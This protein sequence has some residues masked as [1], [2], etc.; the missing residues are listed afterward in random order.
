MGSKIKIWSV[1]KGKIQ[2]VA[3]G[4]GDNRK[5]ITVNGF[6]ATLDNIRLLLDQDPK[7]YKILP[8]GT[9]P[10]EDGANTVETNHPEKSGVKDGDVDDFEA[11]VKGEQRWQSSNQEDSTEE[12]PSSQFR[13]D[14]HKLNSDIVDWEEMSTIENDICPACEKGLKNHH[15]VISHLSSGS[16]P[17][18]ESTTQQHQM[19]NIT[20]EKLLIVVTA[21]TGPIGERDTASLKQLI[22]ETGKGN[23][24]APLESLGESGYI[25]ISSSGNPDNPKFEVTND[26]ISKIISTFSS[27]PERLSDVSPSLASHLFSIDES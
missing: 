11:W 17:A 4:E 3:I 25:N 27:N 13:F 22:Q 7:L 23:I 12:A 5:I 10:K 9:P 26:G 19:L 16:C 20:K 24:K 14:S 18:D 2:E 21:L 8:I 6:D 1:S 15:G